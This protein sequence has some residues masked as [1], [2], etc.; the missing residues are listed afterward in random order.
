LEIGP[1]PQ[2]FARI[3]KAAIG[4]YIR[5]LNSF[6]SICVGLAGGHFRGY[7]PFDAPDILSLVSEDDVTEFIR[8]RLIPENMAISIIT[9]KG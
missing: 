8:K 5:S 7:D 3:K 9:P 2:L 1:D 4:S 6:E